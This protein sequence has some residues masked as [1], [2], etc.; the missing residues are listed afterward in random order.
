MPVR[1]IQAL[2]PEPATVVDFDQVVHRELLPRLLSRMAARDALG[3]QFADASLNRIGQTAGEFGFW[4]EVQGLNLGLDSSSDRPG[5]EVGDPRPYQP[6]VAEEHFGML[7][8]R[9]ARRPLRSL[10]T[11]RRLER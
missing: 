11:A 4:H 8:R 1:Q 9:R 10:L 7:C 5:M 2:K 3:D 6:K